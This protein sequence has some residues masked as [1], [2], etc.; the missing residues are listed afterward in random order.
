VHRDP[1]SPSRRAL[2]L[3]PGTVNYFYNQSGRRVAE[4][5]GELGFGVDVTTLDAC[6]GGDFEIG[7]L[8]NIWE[9]LVAH[10]DEADGLSR[11]AAV[12]GRCR[13]MVSLAIDCVATPWY[14]RIHDLSTRAGSSLVLDF[15]LFDQGAFLRPEHRATYRFVFSGLTSSEAR[16]LDSL[17]G[18]DPQRTIPWAMVG[19][20][21]PHRAALADRLVQC[22]DPRGF[23]YMPARAPYTE[24]GSPHLNQEQ[25]E[26]VLRRSRYQVWCS[27][28]PYF[29]M[30]TERF[31]TS[32]LTGGVP[33]KIVAS[34]DEVPGSVPLSD[35]IME[36]ADVGDRLTTKAFPE[37]R[38][39]FW[40]AWRRFPTLCQGLADAFEGIGIGTRH[41]P[42]IAA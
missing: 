42:S 21:T 17:D 15:G 6:P 33:I 14:H 38:R 30:E 16:M 13:A 1:N 20:M 32:L 11:L 27:H 37:L 10:G 34:R 35:L 31:R 7:V 41:S 12:G 24:T 40:D 29:Y 26:Q 4:A 18:D 3:I 19:A 23:L 2:V 5:L 28:H 22:V 36:A 8:S 25:F 9:I 39:R